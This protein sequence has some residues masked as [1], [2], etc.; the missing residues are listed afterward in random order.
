M[1]FTA[2]GDS[3][4]A[5]AQQTYNYNPQ[6]DA[7]TDF[8][9]GVFN[10]ISWNSYSART[11]M[12]GACTATTT[13]D[14]TKAT[15]TQLRACVPSS[16]AAACADAGAGDRRCVD[17]NGA[18]CG[19]ALPNAIVVGDSATVTCGACGC[20]RG[21]AKCVVGLYSDNACASTP[22]YTQ[23][24]DGQCHQSNS[25]IGVRYFKVHATGLTCAATPGAA[26]PSLVNPRTLC[27]E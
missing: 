3:S 12:G 21:A 11:P 14:A 25:A 16:P 10:L 27:C 22:K 15:S 9:L 5:C 23:D 17:S 1:T 13:T 2:K 24:T 18:A 26:V 6:G 7:C 8:G 19:G 20:T 4:N